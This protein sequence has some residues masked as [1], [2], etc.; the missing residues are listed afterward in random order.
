MKRPAT[1]HTGQPW[2]I[3][4]IAPD[5]GLIDV[6]ELPVS[7]GPEDFPRLVDLIVYDD[8]YHVST[9][10]SHLLFAIRW[11]VG[12]ILGWDDPGQRAGARVPSLLERLPP[13]LRDGPRGPENPDDDFTTIYMTSNEWVAELA[14]R[15]VHA[16]VHIGWVPDANGHF[17]GQL[18][19]LAKPNGRLGRV[20][21]R[22]IDPFRIWLVYPTMMRALGRRWAVR[23][24]VA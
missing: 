4:A 16:L 7:G 22:V 20:Y 17:H 1:A 3:H 14:N 5:F 8:D 9:R 24:E 11:K 13:D 2:R 19:I 15:T 23:Q 21:L 10:A 12:R 6:W 18:A